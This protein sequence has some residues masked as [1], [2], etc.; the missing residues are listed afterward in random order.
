MTFLAELRRLRRRPSPRGGKLPPIGPAWNREVNKSMKTDG[1]CGQNASV[2]FESVL[3]VEFKRRILLVLL[4]KAVADHER[5]DF[6][7][8]EAAERILDAAHDRL[9]AH[10]EAGVHQD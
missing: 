9:A 1:A 4:E 8:H 5:I 7:A 2:Q 10:V 6:G 3:V